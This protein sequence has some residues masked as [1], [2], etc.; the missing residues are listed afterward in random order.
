MWTH[1]K[2]NVAYITVTIQF[3]DSHWSVSSLVLGTRSVKEKHTAECI[4]TNVK[5]VLE[6]F[7]AWCA[8]NA[9]VTDNASNM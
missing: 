8:D 3:T 9:Y 2:T 4:R 1:Q 6:E 5:Q 7:G